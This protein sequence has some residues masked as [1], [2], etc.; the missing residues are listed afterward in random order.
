MAKQR[1]DLIRQALSA[2]ESS[3][4]L[5]R[6][7]LNELE[8]DTSPRSGS[9]NQVSK[10]MPGVIGV[11]DGHNMV[12]ESGETFEVPEN[13]ASKSI[14][15]VGDTLKLVD[16]KGE[17]RFRQIEHVKRHKTTGILTKKE[18]KWAVV[19]SEGSY[20]IL[21]ASVD[22][23]GGLVGDEALVQL[24]AK[25]LQVPFAAVEKIARRGELDVEKKTRNPETEPK[26]KDEVKPEAVVREKEEKKVEKNDPKPV[27]G[28]KEEVPAKVEAKE[29]KTDP[30]R[31][32]E[33]PKPKEIKKQPEP[34]KAPVEP[35][36][37]NSTQPDEDELS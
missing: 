16:D 35:K 26:E 12:T 31:K 17:K 28:K 30:A 19:T 22:H 13:Y 23:F 21:A 11:Y 7:L 2:S 1:I 20:K 10:N 9:S 34:V 29:N 33:E 4:R 3:I 15:V 5:A 6:T 24:P 27:D 8:R 37:T 14:L 25:N 32:E 18:G 36:S